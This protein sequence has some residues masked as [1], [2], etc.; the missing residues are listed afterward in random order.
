M[1][2]K[3]TTLARYNVRIS[4]DGPRTLV[5]AHGFGCDQNMWRFV[6][7]R[8]EDRYRVVLFDYLGMGGSDRS[9]YSPQR[10]GT[11]AAYA[12]DLV[13]I[14]EA[15]DLK[16][17]LLVA[18]SVSSMIGAL[19]TLQSP[20]LFSQLV[21]VGPSP[22]Y[23]NDDDYTGGFERADLE[24]LLD[25]MDRNYIGWASQLTPVIMKNAERPELTEELQRSFCSTD[26]LVAK[27]FAEATF[28]SDNRADLDRIS[29]PTL[30]LQCADDAIAPAQVGRYMHARMPDST[31]HYLRA[32]GHC[33]HMSHPDETSAAIDTYLSTLAA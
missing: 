14:C 11:L 19:A 33:P 32:T 15:L 6:A 10:Y 27:R 16:D 2:D 4:G 21:M 28:L 23:F 9:A 29:V 12:E 24:G 26:P 30:I 17:A 1:D 22:C 5:F 25:M 7:P 8:F 31:L 3:S 20:G 18:H 13:E